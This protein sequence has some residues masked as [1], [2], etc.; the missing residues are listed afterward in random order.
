MNLESKIDTLIEL[1]NKQNLININ[2]NKLIWLGTLN[3]LVYLI[4]CLKSIGKIPI[5]TS[6]KTI[7][8]CFLCKNK[9]IKQN[10]ISDVRSK[11]N[12]KF[13]NYFPSNE[14]V[15]LITDYSNYLQN[16]I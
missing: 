3:D 5:A 9:V 13:S 4:E 8:D 11:L 12:D 2:S 1:I 16:N 14:I 7:S 10:V 15:D 6:N